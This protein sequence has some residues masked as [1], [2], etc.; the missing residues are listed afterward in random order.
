MLILL[1]IH[2]YS[3]YHSTSD[4]PLF[5]KVLASALLIV[6]LPSPVHTSILADITKSPSDVEVID[7]PLTATPLLAVRRS[8]PC[9]V[10]PAFTFDE[11]R[12]RSF[13][14]WEVRFAHPPDCNSVSLGRVTVQSRE[15]WLPTVSG[16]ST[17]LAIDYIEADK[18]LPGPPTCQFSYRGTECPEGYMSVSSSIQKNLRTTYCCFR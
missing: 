6:T 5:A 14:T 4:S 18:C 10:N 12:C 7:A 3:V 8:E 13:L 1:V 16:D 11:D 15:L 2:P 9:I 17:I